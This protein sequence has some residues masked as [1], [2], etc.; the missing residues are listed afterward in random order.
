L[1][2]SIVV[3]A[4]NEE[5]H[6]KKFI[7]ETVRVMDRLG[8]NYEIVIVDDGSIDGTR[9]EAQLATRN[10]HVRV[11]GYDRNIGKGYALKYGFKYTSGDVI[12][13]I[14]GDSEISSKQIM[15]YIKAVERGDLLIASKWH[16]ES[17]TEIPIIRRFLSHGFHLLVNLS[18]RLR[19]SDTQSGMK[20][21][22]RRVL[23]K[24]LPKLVFTQFAFDV[25]LL[26]VANLYGYKI[27]ELPVSIQMRG[28]IELKKLFKMLFTMLIELIG[29]VYRLRI[30]K[31]YLKQ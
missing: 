3:P 22:K 14:D 6:I 5:Q 18:T 26:T 28:N 17:C 7:E 16:P 11:V 15:Q 24:I 29:I 25:E 19:V 20:V 30:S 4:Y 23:D 12:A 8:F 27:V 31:K 21:F 2:V 9:E 13:F 1:K 10:S